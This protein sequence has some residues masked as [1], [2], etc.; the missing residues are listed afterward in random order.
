MSYI[1]ITS[2]N[3]I[4]VNSEYIPPVSVKSLQNNKINN[5]QKLYI[6]VEYDLHN[7]NYEEYAVD[8]LIFKNKND[9]IEYM[10]T[11]RNYYKMSIEE[12]TLYKKDYYL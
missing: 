6:I 8:G 10:Y 12:L 2:N 5:T 9:A 11:K 3:N 4:K 7:K 1:R